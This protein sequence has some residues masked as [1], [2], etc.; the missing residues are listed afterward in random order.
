MIV[1]VLAGEGWLEQH[2][3]LE[4]EALQVRVQQLACRV[5]PGS[6]EGVTGNHG[7]VGVVSDPLEGSEP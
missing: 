4:T 1:R 6:L 2:G 3:G 7:G 5:N